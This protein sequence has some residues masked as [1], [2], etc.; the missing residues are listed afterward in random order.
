MYRHIMYV[1]LFNSI[2]HAS[3]SM[4]NTA[5]FIGYLCIPEVPVYALE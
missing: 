4:I 3:N 1:V 2:F 5:T